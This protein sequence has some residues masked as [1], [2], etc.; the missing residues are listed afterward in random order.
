[1]AKVLAVL[2]SPRRNGN[3]ACLAEQV[4]SGARSL[5]ATTETVYLHELEI[6]PCDAC[7]LC[8]G[9]TYTGCV[10][11]DDMQMLYPKIIEADAIVIA[12]PIYWFT[13]SAQTKLFIDRGYALKSKDGYVLKGK[14]MGIVLSYED[15]DPVTSGAVNAIRTF[16]DISAYVKAT[17]TGFV[18]GRA[19]GP[20]EIAKNAGLME[21]AFELGKKL[22]GES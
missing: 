18:Y 22:V 15:S 20:G 7:D 13:V 4:M 5:G 9:D 16:Q 11:D 3:S 14:R 6:K 2:G 21:E 19:A 17:I 1:M 8:E 12:S 10:I